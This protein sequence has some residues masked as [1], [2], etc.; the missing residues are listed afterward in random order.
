MKRKKSPPIVHISL[1]DHGQGPG[2]DCSPWPCEVIG[3][4]YRED[5]DHYWVCPWVANGDFKSKDSESFIL[6]KAACHKIR[7]LK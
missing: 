5:E 3:Y 6:V 7:R 2:D 4:L 1:L